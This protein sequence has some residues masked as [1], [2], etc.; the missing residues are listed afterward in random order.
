MVSEATTDNNPASCLNPQMV[1]LLHADVSY[2]VF[3]A[4]FQTLPPSTNYQIM[5]SRGTSRH[6]TFTQRRKS[7][8]MQS[9]FCMQK[10]ISNIQLLKC[11]ITLVTGLSPAA[12]IL[13]TNSSGAGLYKKSLYF[14]YLYESYPLISNVLI[15]PPEN[16]SCKYNSAVSH[17]LFQDTT[18]S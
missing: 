10:S 8:Q 7:T 18:R 12:K 11:L 2:S 15:H 1:H 9:Y 3:S 17:S 14:E 5:L 4:V 13:Y 16:F 6:K